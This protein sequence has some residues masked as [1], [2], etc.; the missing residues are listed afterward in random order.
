MTELFEVLR[1]GIV[2]TSDFICGYPLFIWLIGGGLFLFIYS[3]AIPLRRLKWSMKALRSKTPNGEGEISSFQA[4]MSSICSTVGMGNIAGVAIAI[5]IGGA[6]AI[7]WMWVSALLGMATKF[8]EGT[9]AIMYKGKDKE[10]V[11][12]GGPMY[13]LT[14][15]LGKQ[16]KPLAIFFA[17]FGMIGTLCF[18]QANQLT[19]SFIT[20][21][22]APDTFNFR[23]ITG[24][25]MGAGVSVV[26]LGGITR[27]SK[28][29]TKVVPIMVGLYFLLVF[30]IIIMN[31]NLLPKVFYN[32]VNEAFNLEAGF[33]ALAFI[34]LTGARRAMYVNEAGVGTAS[35][36]HGASR[37]ASP[38]REGLVAMIG[39]AVDSGL[40]CTL[41][42][43]PILM[44]MQV[45]PIEVEGVKGLYIALNAFET[46]LPGWGEYALMVI[47]FIFAVTTMFS[48][49][50]YGTQ[51][52]GYLFGYKNGKYYDYFYLFMIIVACV[53]SLDLV[54]S[55]MDLAFA[56]MTIPTM[57]ALFRL[58]PRVKK[59][60]KI[61][62][63]NNKL[64]N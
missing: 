42:A 2:A 8:F 30:I 32:I 49:S 38:V 17:F 39:P 14:E 43:I 55:I 12:H 9:L 4:L 62:F 15:G 21:L 11:V 24:L 29:A 18:M 20:V 34:A 22:D 10:G 60:M 25:I 3:G 35:L 57:Y 61:Y 41:T 64:D 33:G 27:I 56:F 51:C 13:M 58:S 46:M 36:M 59:E 6:G 47:V 31:I 19:E 23:L 50:Y 48:Y 28:I 45:S 44:A 40:V 52:A 63:D 26:V 7:F 54:V 16:F 1:K 37:N 5:S 53:I